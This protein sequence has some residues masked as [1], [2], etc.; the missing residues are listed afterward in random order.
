MCTCNY[1][2][3]NR[4]ASIKVFEPVNGA[5]IKTTYCKRHFDELNA[6][7]PYLLSGKKI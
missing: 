3:C 1:E 5:M 4:K 2:G 6:N 7:K